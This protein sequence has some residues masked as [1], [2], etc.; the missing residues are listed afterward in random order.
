MIIGLSYFSHSASK[1]NLNLSYNVHLNLLNTLNSRCEH[2]SIVYQ[3]LF[4]Y[5]RL[6]ENYFSLPT[7]NRFNNPVNYT[8]TSRQL[9]T[10]S[11]DPDNVK[12]SVFDQDLG[13]VLTCEPEMITT[14]ASTEA[15]SQEIS[16]TIVPNERTTTHTID[17]L[18]TTTVPEDATTITGVSTTMLVSITE[19]TVTPETTEVTDAIRTLE[20]SIQLAVIE[21]NGG[22]SSQLRILI[23]VCIP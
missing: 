15:N 17:E 3:A 8:V 11:L 10:N 13:N 16:S 5:A 12:W 19:E 22:L 23:S 1:W 6:P 4:L 2:P 18:L 9:V 20:S 14:T 7:T 21:S